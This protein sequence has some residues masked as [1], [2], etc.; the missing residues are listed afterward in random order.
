MPNFN[1]NYLSSMFLDIAGFETT[2]T[3]CEIYT[4]IIKIILQSRQTSQQGTISGFKYGYLISW[5][6]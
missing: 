5:T 6:N 2:T 3:I 1:L 4:Q